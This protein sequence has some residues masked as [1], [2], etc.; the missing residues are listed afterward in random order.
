L[1]FCPEKSGHTNFRP[2]LFWIFQLSN[3]K[4]SGRKTFT[5]K[6]FT[7]FNFRTKIF[8]VFK[9]SRP[10]KVRVLELHDLRPREQ[11][12]TVMP[13]SCQT[14]NLFSNF[15]ANFFLIFQLSTGIFFGFSYFEPE[16]FRPGK[17]RGKKDPA[18]PLSNQKFLP[19]NNFRLYDRTVIGQKNCGR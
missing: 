13:V 17:F 12:T 3:Q 5:P 16:N 18:V 15:R 11:F 4:K 19:G 8:P 1:D 6:F 7:I 14:D 2:E 10:K 9:I